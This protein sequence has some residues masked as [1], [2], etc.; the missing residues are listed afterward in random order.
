MTRKRGLCW[1]YAALMTAALMAFVLGLTEVRFAVNDDAGI[2]RAFM[3]YESGAPARFH[4]YIHGL[5]A[6]PL[7]WL[8]TAFPALPWFTY[9]QLALLALACVVSAK[10][11]MQLFVKNEK[12]L[13]LGAVFAA[14]FLL[15]LCFKYIVR[16]TFTQTSAMLGAAAILQM[17]SVEHDRG[18][19]RVVLGMAG[20]LALVALSYSLRQITALPVLAY[21]GLAFVVLYARHY[22]RKRPVKPMLVS[23]LLVVVVMG[24]LAG[25]RELEIRN[26]GAQ[27]YLEWQES[28]TDVIDFYGLANVPEEAFR[29]AGWDG[30]TQAMA[31]KWCFLDSDISTEAF[32]TLEAYMDAHDARTLSD[33]LRAAWDTFAGVL[34]ANPQ[35]V[36]CLLIAVIAGVFALIGLIRSRRRVELPGLLA[37]AFGALVMVA[38]LAY[39]GRLPLRALLMVLL[40]LAAFV[41]ALLPSAVSRRGALAVCA[42]LCVGLTAWCLYA[43]VP[44][45]LPDPQEELELGNAMGD[46]EEYALSEEDSLFIY[47]DTLVGADLRAFPKYPDGVPHNVT[48]WGGWGLRSPESMQQFERFGIDLNDFDPAALLRED[49]F[50][51]SGRVDP[52][53]QVILNW[54]HEKLGESIDWEIWSE[55]GNVYI[56]HFYEY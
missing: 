36:R 5:L 18:A 27:A 4:I 28:N 38:Y 2:L 1:L 23:L 44:G 17:F 11:I 29:L 10:S 34:R 21:C 47:D 42:A 41:F 46:L 52:P 16:L 24:G 56:F 33:R 20:A 22:H 15:T 19:W 37:A 14:A 50:I 30:A 12:P 43:I 7:C 3:G 49:V 8:S 45:V 55:Y 35:D 6:L 26:S 54:L 32:R 31:G 13:W 9:L 25:V 40:P 48:F 53:P 51:A 39:G